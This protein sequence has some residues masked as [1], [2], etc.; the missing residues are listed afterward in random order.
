VFLAKLFVQIQISPSSL[1][2][3]GVNVRKISTVVLNMISDASWTTSIYERGRGAREEESEG[4][5]G[6]NWIMSGEAI[7]LECFK[8][9]AVNLFLLVSL[10]TW[11]PEKRNPMPESGGSRHQGHPKKSNY[12][13]ARLTNQIHFSFRVGKL[14]FVTKIYL[15][16]S[17][18]HKLDRIGSLMLLNWS[19]M[20]F[21]DFNL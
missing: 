11:R 9:R 15:V 20:W 12:V 18:R 7:L 10:R 3:R 4:Y 13:S 17:G 2:T 16:C 1:F 14:L 8:F 19:K 21:E 5:A 6:E